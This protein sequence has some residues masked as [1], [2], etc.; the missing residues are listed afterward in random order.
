MDF[1]TIITISFMIL[2]SLNVLALYYKPDMKYAN[3]VGCF[4][5]WETSKE[6]PDVHD[7]V[8][9]SLIGLRGQKLYLSCYWV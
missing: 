3:A 1:L 7:F 5:A 6:N 4:K 8:L 9:I 2:E